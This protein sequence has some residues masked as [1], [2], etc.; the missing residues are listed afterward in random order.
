MA[1]TACD[2]ASPTYSVRSGPMASPCGSPGSDQRRMIFESSVGIAASGVCTCMAIAADKV[3]S[4][5]AAAVRLLLECVGEVFD[6]RVPEELLA[7]LP[8]LLLDFRS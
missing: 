5:I 8:N 7:H 4:P 3:S 1:T 2:C 6:D